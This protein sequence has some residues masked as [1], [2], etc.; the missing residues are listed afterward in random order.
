[1][2]RCV[3]L[4]LREVPL[5]R[6]TIYRPAFWFMNDVLRYKSRLLQKHGPE[7][8][9]RIDEISRRLDVGVYPTFGTLLGIIR[10]GGL[11]KHDSDMDFAI[12]P[13]STS[14]KAFFCEIQRHGFTFEWMETV[15]G[16]LSEVRFRYRELPVDFFLHSYTADG[17][18]LMLIQTDSTTRRYEYPLVKSLTDYSAMG[19]N[20]RIP[21][22][23]QEYLTS[24]YGPW[25]TVVKSG[26]SS[27]MAPCFIGVDD[28]SR[29][30]IAT[31]RSI[32]DFA[33][34]LE[35]H[36]HSDRLRD[37]GYSRR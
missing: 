24:L 13:T 30:A 1:M 29:Y 2:V 7:A 20:L 32:D 26:W 31:S 15:D 10:D 27:T 6:K 18:K 4:L 12:L 19:I 9:R 16:C 25:N 3:R 11:L 22:N 34:W 33:Q 21:A 5:L 37:K 8:L 17:K 35:K 28:A 23:T 36:P 14:L